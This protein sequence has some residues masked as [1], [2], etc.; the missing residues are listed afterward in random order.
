MAYKDKKL[1]L[2]KQILISFTIIMT[3]TIMTI[4][5]FVNKTF[6]SQFSKY[7]DDSNKSEVNHLVFDLK[8]VYKDSLWDIETIKSLGEDAISKGIALE[9]Y[10]VDNTL[11]WSI[12]KDEKMLS[13]KTLTTI[14]HNMKTIDQNWN[15]ELQEY[16][17][18]IYDDN[19]N[20]VGYEKIVHYDSIYYMENDIEFINIMNKFMLII[21]IL[22]LSSI[23]IISIVI[24][25]S[26]SNPIE[27][28]SSMSKVIEK[29]NY[30]ERL[31]YISNIQEVDELINSI[32]TL[33]DALNDQEILRKNLTTDIAHELRTPITSVQGHLDAIIDGIW[34]PTPD[35]L[36]SIREEVSRI[37]TLIGELKN[38]ANF[39]NEKNKL[40]K[41]VINIKYLI[42]NILYNYESKALNKNINIL[43]DL[44]DVYVDVDK[45]Q[46]SQVVINLLSNAIKYTNQNGNIYVKIYLENNIPTLS[47][48]DTGIGIP[49]EDLKY[50]FERF[51]RVDKSRNKET[52]GIGVGLTIVKAI[53]STHNGT[54][55]VYS[56]LG[57]GTEFIIKLPRL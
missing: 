39:D 36:I 49:K 8:N 2:N 18:D 26:I 30:K 32:N 27:K 14:K 37:G 13:N 16:K 57:K 20:L 5:V 54:I 28:V 10:D 56:Q 4:G 46:F 9:I 7:V 40:N 23:M 48:K 55:S 33:G 21:S 51:Y 47:I 11:I 22:S 19:E 17:F 52:G 43:S 45:D 1:S 38:L 3:L 25:K 12:F 24:A 31:S 6:E 50:I 35:R 44:K 42:Q 34:D 15:G 29:G 41:N 53:V